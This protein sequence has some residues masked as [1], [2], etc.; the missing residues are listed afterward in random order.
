MR[1]LKKLKRS[2]RKRIGF[3]G[4][5]DHLKKKKPDPE[6]E[7]NQQLKRKWQRP[8]KFQ[9]IGLDKGTIGWLGRKRV[10]L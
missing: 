5:I 8:I 2:E 3:R 9:M 7:E 6:R 1:K 4:K 10:R